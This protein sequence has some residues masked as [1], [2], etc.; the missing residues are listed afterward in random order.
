[1]KFFKFRERKKA[2]QPTP[3]PPPQPKKMKINP[4][5]L[6]MAKLEKAKKK[7]YIHAIERYEP[8]AGVI[9]EEIRDAVLAM[10][11]TPYGTPAFSSMTMGQSG[12]PGYPYLAQLTQRPEFRKMVSVNA[13]EMTRK[14]VT[15][16]SVGDE[17]KSEK[18]ALL[19]K[20][21]ERYNVREL[22]KLAMEHDG[23][24]GR[25]Q[26]YIE[27][28]TPKGIA[29]STDPVELET[30][31]FRSNKK[32][33]KGSLVAFRC[34]EPMWTYPGMYNASDPLAADYY[35][36]QSWYVMGKE[37]HAS[38]FLSFVSRPV[39]DV[40]KAAYNFGGLSLSQIAEPYVDN[41]IRTRDSVGDMVHS[42]STSGFKTN[43]QS[44]L[45]GGS[46]SDIFDRA[47]LFNNLR[48]NRGLMILDQQ[49]EEF[50]QFNT[51]LSGLDTLQAQSQEHMCS[52]SGQPL[53][54]FTGI[55]PNGL[56][57]SSDGE[58]RVFYDDIHAEQEAVF[59]DNLVEVLN[60]IQ[61]SE[62]GEIDTDISFRFEALMELSAEEKANIRKTEA[63]TDDIL[64][65][66]VGS[67][68]PDDSRERLAN[69]PDSPYHSLETNSNDELED[70]EESEENTDENFETGST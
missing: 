46:G 25:G 1:M 39:P 30:R 58:I 51:P 40:L 16:T 38:R 49:S 24:F 9:P 62:F 4:V 17:D 36:P 42:Y 27:V 70:E 21:M 55:T 33:T 54:K 20:A 48:D 15:L 45:A 61:L 57:A 63:E 28:R 23:F 32:I 53:V 14:W 69:D 10:D 5:L 2:E 68:S 43:L 19:E 50:F 7:K 64:V 29:A 67:L 65:N 22:F 8:P 56:N 34:V 66:N 13:K 12:F 59:R 31:L 26:I 44:T 6:T 37:V 35:K 52:V 18:I 3:S 60:I 41:W 47:E 11:S